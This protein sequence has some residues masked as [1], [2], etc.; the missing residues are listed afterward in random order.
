MLIRQVN[1]AA[2]VSP[3][4]LVGGVESAIPIEK[5]YPQNTP[6]LPKWKERAKAQLP[7]CR[8]MFLKSDF[9]VRCAK[10]TQH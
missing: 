10:S 5:F 9:D 2:P 8:E 4:Y 1:P 7:G 3:F 6:L